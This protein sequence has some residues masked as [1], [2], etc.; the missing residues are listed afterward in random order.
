[1]ITIEIFFFGNKIT[2]MRVIGHAGAAPH[3][4]DIVCAGVSAL[5]QSAV[6]GLESH[7]NRKLSLTVAGGKLD[8]ALV[9]EPD[10]L[11]E[12]ILSTMLLGLKEIAK[13][14]P[15][16]VRIEERRR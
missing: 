2:R 9:E 10:C 7:L 3:G 1:M 4:Q 15:K 11:S 13:L 16:S 6:L 12:A 5:T 8:C 14:N